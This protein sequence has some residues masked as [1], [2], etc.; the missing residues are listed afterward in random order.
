MKRIYKTAA[1]LLSLI[2]ILSSFC[3]METADAAKDTY[4]IESADD[5][6]ALARSC[7]LDSYSRQLMV[8]L[9]NDIDLKNS[10]F[11]NIPCFCGS[12]NGGGFTIKNYS[13]SS[14]G[15]DMGFFRLISDT[16]T[17]YDLNIKGNVKPA[18]S[19]NN[20]GGIA[21]IN[22]GTILHCS[23]SG[24]VTG[25][26]G[27]GGIAGENNGSI[28]NC[29]FSGTA[30]GEHSIGGIAGNNNGL[31]TNCQ[32]N[33]NI[34]TVIAEG[35]S[36]SGTSAVTNI[37]SMDFDI[38]S[39]SENDFLDIADVGGIAGFSCGNIIHCKN[40]GKTGYEH[41][42][43]NVGGIVGR[44]SGYT[45][46]C[47]NEG[48]V[49]GRKDVGGITGQIEPY[50]SWDYSQ[51]R[52]TA[53]KN[54]LNDVNRK[55]DTLRADSSGM[56]DSMRADL[57]A[58]QGYLHTASDNTQ[59]M[60][61]N[62]S[63]KLHTI[64]ADT[65]EIL[66]QL[67]ESIENGDYNLTDKLI[68]RIQRL[69]SKGEL[70]TQES[71]TDILS[72]LTDAE[73]GLI[74]KLSI[75]SQLENIHDELSSSAES[76][77]E[78]MQSNPSEVSFK[79]ISEIRED[80][81]SR[82]EEHLSSIDAEISSA[83]ESMA[84]EINSRVTSRYSSAEQDIISDIQE[85]TDTNKQLEKV[86]YF[87]SSLEQMIANSS[88][89]VVDSSVLSDDLANIHNSSLKLK[90][91]LADESD[92]VKKDWKALTNSISALYDTITEITENLDNTN[93]DSTA[94]ISLESPDKYTNG[95]VAY[96]TN[97]GDISAET[98]TGGIVGSLSVEIEFDAEDQLNISKFVLSDGQYQIFAVVKSCESIGDVTSKKKCAGGITGNADFGALIDCT[99]A[100]TM[101]VSSGDYCGGI[102]GKC[103][104]SIQ[105]CYSRTLLY[106]SSYIGG[107]AGD[108]SVISSCM[109]YSYI[110]SG[111]EYT[112]SIAGHCSGTTDHCL[113]VENE[114][115]G[116]DGISYE[117]IAEPIA[118]NEII[119]LEN[120]P[121]LFKKIV[122]T[123][124]VDDETI[125]EIEVAFGGSIAKLP[126]VPNKGLKYWKW[127]DFN[128]ER[129]YY[130]I[131]V[132]GQYY[133][134][135]TTISTE[136]D[137]PL[138]LAE[139]HFYE[140]QKLRY[141]SVDHIPD[142]T[143]FKSKSIYCSYKV[144]VSHY[145]DDLVVR[146]KTDDAGTLYAITKD[147][148]YKEINYETDGS[149][150]VFLLSNGGSFVYVK[151]SI[152]LLPFIIIIPV[153]IAAAVIIIILIIKK[154]RRKP[155]SVMKADQT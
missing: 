129:I 107:I 89:P 55:I 7:M 45:S 101:T 43:Y 126:E 136:G 58:L 115:G 139:G 104:G 28:V 10:G 92:A 42:G 123:F 138:F 47:V 137:H 102:A 140:G 13:F 36:A 46:Y 85:N 109:A 110:M 21:G 57:D 22:N 84:S 119:Q 135:K 151:R 134:P 52:L 15:S 75:E 128:Q 50:T 37:F 14:D 77:I 121:E 146:M 73:T 150:I 122:V 117:G 81:S 80:I 127:D 61:N 99:A 142:T 41:T 23:F 56:S 114:T 152:S 24:T 49:L 106:G 124:I 38:S 155:D 71:L 62:A 98:N 118:Y 6:M 65:A 112:G 33:G 8:I 1:V 86:R 44:Q 40:T 53:L 68:S 26:D 153:V 19:K 90:D 74:D 35:T 64:N 154:H 130:S 133:N 66:R 29:T 93:T 82:A 63:D 131:T 141:D 69:F 27:I 132:N 103:S 147:G 31:I 91:D 11:K 25:A 125:D 9:K 116:I 88:Q 78:S 95:T 79:D 32:N 70:I 144:S 94:D 149:Y 145:T 17:I 100:G 72:A 48:I 20:I 16:A 83:N 4:Y 12:F 3:G 87:I 97:N 39:V 120:T 67:N 34:N 60:I 59:T 2:M 76:V 105:S 18:G 143:L 108:S 54:N 96:C 51:S 148:N 111:N 30:Y 113:F 5:L